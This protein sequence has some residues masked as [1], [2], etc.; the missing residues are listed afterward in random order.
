M[1]R[2]AALCATGAIAFAGAAQAQWLAKQ[3]KRDPVHKVV[4]T[5]AANGCV[6]TAA[7]WDRLFAG[8]GGTE[9]DGDYHVLMMYQHGELTSKDGGASVRLTGVGGC[10]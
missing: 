7:D 2:L 10:P 1:T 4:A 6:V 5:V 9:R 3:P 8:Y